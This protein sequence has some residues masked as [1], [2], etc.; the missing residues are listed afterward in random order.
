VLYLGD[1]DWCGNQIES[2]TK[3]VLEH[4]TG[5]ELAWK[6]VA[7]TETQI[8]KH[9]LPVIMKAD[10]RYKPP[11]YHEAVETEAISQ[12]IL[13]EIL[14][15]HLRELLPEPLEHV[16]EREAFQRRQISDMF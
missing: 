11:R 15:K 8:R 6:R 12:R 14:R 9:K 3:R 2:N 1:A 4:E 7:L 10:R 5:G 13:V 16:L